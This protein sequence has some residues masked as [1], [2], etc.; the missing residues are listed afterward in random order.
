MR[1][2]KEREDM[3]INKR[4]MINEDVDEKNKR[5]KILGE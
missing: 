4:S 1:M 2:R 5:E 3:R